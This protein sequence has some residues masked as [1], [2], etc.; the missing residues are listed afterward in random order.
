[1]QAQPWHTAGRQ[2]CKGSHQAPTGQSADA[3]QST[4]RAVALSHT[5]GQSL[6]L[7][8]FGLARHWRSAQR[9]P[10]LQSLSAVQS[11]QRPAA[12][13]QIWPAAA[14]AIELPHD[15]AAL[16]VFCSQS[17]PGPQWA[18]LAQATQTRRSPSHVP[19]PQLIAP[20]VQGMAGGLQ[21]G[22]GMWTHMLG[23]PKQLSMVQTSL[24][25]HAAVTQPGAAT[26]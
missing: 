11:T 17:S 14:H 10:V 2:R 1:M 24:S 4:Q 25:S 19:A 15:L 5:P 22:T 26:S 7:L 12:R 21:L 20:A 8:Q 23:F 9:W 16:Q 13:S 3:R 18:S 6:S